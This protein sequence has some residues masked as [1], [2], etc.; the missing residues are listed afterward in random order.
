MILILVTF[1]GPDAARLRASFADVI[2]GRIFSKLKPFVPSTHC[3]TGSAGRSRFG[4][5]WLEVAIPPPGC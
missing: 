1:S 5:F 3:V 2:N 4:H